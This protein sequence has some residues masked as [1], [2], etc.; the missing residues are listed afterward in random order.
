MLNL[1]TIKLAAYAGALGGVLFLGIFIGKGIEKGSSEKKIAEVRDNLYSC[2]QTVL[3]IQIQSQNAIESMQSQINE[4]AKNANEQVKN[5][6][7]ILDRAESASDGLRDKARRLEDQYR[8][9]ANPA[10]PSATTTETPYLLSDMLDRIDRAS[11]EIAEYADRVTI[12][13]DACIASYNAK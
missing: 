10:K 13:H 2:Q 6:E 3:E 9:C 12:A 11:G 1:T 8:K 7:I 5:L 4:A